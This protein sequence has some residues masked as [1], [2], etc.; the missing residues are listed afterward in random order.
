MKELVEFLIPYEEKL[1]ANVER[2]GLEPIPSPFDEDMSCLIQRFIQ[3]S[4]EER[5]FI[6]SIFSDKHSFAFIGFSQRMAV[7][8]VRKRSE[9]YL[10]EGLIAHV[11]EGGKF[12]WRENVLVLSLLYHSAVKIGADPVALFTRAA[13]LAGKPSAEE[14]AD[15]P[16]AKTIRE[17]PHRAPE[18]RSIQAMGYEEAKDADGFCYKRNW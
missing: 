12:D 3:S 16:I 8:A 18:Y 17:Y 11:I 2:R 10:F 9:K 1:L 6:R 4:D 7:L 15:V 14:L 13:A 5:T